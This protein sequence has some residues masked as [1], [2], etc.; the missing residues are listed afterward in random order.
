MGFAGTSDADMIARVKQVEDSGG[1]GGDY[2]SASAE[3]HQQLL[4]Y[5]ATR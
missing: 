3:A 5:L 1:V 2:L 4:D